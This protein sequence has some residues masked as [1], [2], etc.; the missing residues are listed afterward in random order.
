MKKIKAVLFDMDGVLIDSE[1]FYMEGMYKWM[2][3][4]GFKGS[5]EEI[6]TVIGTNMKTTYEM[7]QKMM[8]NKVSIKELEQANNS[9]FAK[10]PLD[11]KSIM[12]PGA[13][14]LMK[15]LKSKGIKMAV[16]SSSPKDNIDT[17]MEVC[18]FKEY[19]D[20]EISGDQLKHSKPAPDIYL[21]A[22]EV[23]NVTSDECIVIEDSTIGIEA[24]KNANMIVIAYKNDKFK[25]D[26]SYA[27]YSFKSMQEIS[28]FIDGLI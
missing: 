22:S 17:V 25:Q 3:E 9:Y 1:T 2:Q 28:D 5:I 8:N 15:S 6:Y 14:D 24:G 26:Q 20:F 7:L 13:L 16:C 19:L 18:G 27:N 4:I 11:F 21:K 10:H 12:I 23:L